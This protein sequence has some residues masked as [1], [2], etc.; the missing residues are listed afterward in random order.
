ML[1]V[2]EGIFRPQGTAQLLTGNDSSLGLQEQAQYL[3]RLMLNTCGNAAGFPQFTA[4]QIELE[5]VK[6]ST[7]WG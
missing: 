1:E 5:P 3:Q 2:N 4:A 6:T 7:H